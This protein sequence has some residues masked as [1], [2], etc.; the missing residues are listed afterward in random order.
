MNRYHIQMTTSGFE[1][2]M[3][4]KHLQELIVTTYTNKLYQSNHKNFKV[5][6]DHLRIVQ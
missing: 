4:N 3:V 6:Y 1:D 5:K 2:M